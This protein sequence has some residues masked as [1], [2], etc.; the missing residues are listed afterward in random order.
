MKGAARD[1]LPGMAVSVSGEILHRW[2]KC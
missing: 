1:L 2:R